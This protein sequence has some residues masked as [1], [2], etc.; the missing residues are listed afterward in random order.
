MALSYYLGLSF[1]SIVS[2]SV[3]LGTHISLRFS[4]LIC[5]LERYFNLDSPY[6]ACDG[7]YTQG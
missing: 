3:A 4:F 5:L 7:C 2:F 6:K 1:V